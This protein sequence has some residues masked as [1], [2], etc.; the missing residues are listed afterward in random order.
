M[1]SPFNFDGAGSD[2]LRRSQDPSTFERS[3]LDWD[4]LE[5]YHRGMFSWY[6]DLIATRRRLPAVAQAVLAHVEDH[7]IVFS[8]RQGHRSREPRSAQLRGGRDR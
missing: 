5:P 7:R 4:E 8:A 6:R 1:G 3:K 2:E